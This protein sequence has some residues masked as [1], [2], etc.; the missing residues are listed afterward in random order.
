MP[1][2][3]LSEIV[4]HHVVS[5]YY[6]RH[7]R[8][9]WEYF[10]PTDSDHLKL[11]RFNNFSIIC[12]FLVELAF[13]CL[14]NVP[15]WLMHT[16]DLCHASSVAIVVRRWREPALQLRRYQTADKTLTKE[17]LES[18][19]ETAGAILAEQSR[20]AV[21]M[22]DSHSES[23]PKATIWSLK[24]HCMDNLLLCTRKKGSWR[25]SGA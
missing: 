11:I 15:L 6:I 12:Y 23:L 21:E 13:P 10:V 25:L 16:A 18:K 4:S 17:T 2:L 7:K 22:S 19:R 1:H 3:F 14:L 8:D 5:I 20:A 9:R 24:L